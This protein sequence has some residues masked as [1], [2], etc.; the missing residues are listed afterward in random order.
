MKQVGKTNVTGDL[1]ITPWGLLKK[2]TR[3]MGF[4]VERTRSRHSKRR[5]LRVYSH[6]ACPGQGG[7][8]MVEDWC[9]ARPPAR[10]DLD[11]AAARSGREG[12]QIP[13]PLLRRRGGGSS[14]LSYPPPGR[15]SLSCRCGSCGPCR[16]VVHSAAWDPIDGPALAIADCIRSIGGPGLAIVGCSG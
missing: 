7:D 6:P 2:E 5:K 14:D 9:T 3:D 12:S 16:L 4:S 10:Q 15:S 1:L 11:C 13:W 8:P